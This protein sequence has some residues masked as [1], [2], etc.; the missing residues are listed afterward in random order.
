MASAFAHIVVP[1]VAYVTLTN[2]VVGF[3]LFTL[4]AILSVLPDADVIAFTFGV[5]YES[6]WGHRGFTHSLFFSVLVALFCTLFWR[7]LNSHPAVVFAICFVSCAS[8]ALLDGMTNGG[9]GVALYWPLDH[10]RHF[11]PY[12]PFRY[13]LSVLVLFL[14][15]MA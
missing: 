4:A 3:R 2:K 12:R 9:L 8:H 13:R 15:S 10:E 1:A 6:Q 14:V 5:P 7:K 11:L